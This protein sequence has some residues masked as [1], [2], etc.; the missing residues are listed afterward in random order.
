MR[1]PGVQRRLLRAAGKII[2]RNEL[3]IVT[4]SRRKKGRAHIVNMYPFY[5]A[6]AGA[7][8]KQDGIFFSVVLNKRPWSMGITNNENQSVTLTTRVI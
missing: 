4:N 8:D 6:E 1:F 3:N 5:S 7:K 2:I